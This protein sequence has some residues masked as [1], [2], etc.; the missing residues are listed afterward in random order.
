MG[1]HASQDAEGRGSYHRVSSTSV[2]SVRATVFCPEGRGNLGLC[3]RRPLAFS[4]EVV[5]SSKDTSS[6][7]LLC[8][9]VL[10]PTHDLGII[11]SRPWNYPMILSLQPLMGAIAAGCPAVI[12]PS[13]VCP[14]YSSLLASLLPKYLDQSA[15]R[16][17]NGSVPEV[18]HLLK[19]KWDHS[20]SYFRLC[21]HRI[22]VLTWL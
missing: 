13:E 6:A 9:T 15:Y 16:V 20:V 11:L 7:A 1:T 4:R 10:C 17:V 21:S 22:T 14:T 12:K 3:P 19:L 2:T 5:A 18:S 8:I